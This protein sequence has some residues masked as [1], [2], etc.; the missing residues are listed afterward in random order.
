MNFA[1]YESGKTNAIKSDGMHSPLH[2]LDTSRGNSLFPIRP[3]QNK[4]FWRTKGDAVPT[5]DSAA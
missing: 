5:G 4:R 1:L 3:L 2:S